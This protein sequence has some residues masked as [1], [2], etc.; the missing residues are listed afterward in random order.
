LATR[1][2]KNK[3]GGKEERKKRGTRSYGGKKKKF[4][5]E[6]GEKPRGEAA[7]T[8]YDEKGGCHERGEGQKRGT[9]QVN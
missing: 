5:P 2:T 3:G 4:T 8:L 6:D 1:S 9:R 7:L